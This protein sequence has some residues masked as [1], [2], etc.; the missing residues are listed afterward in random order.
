MPSAAV[1][2]SS[3]DVWFARA[4]MLVITPGTLVSRSIR[5]PISLAGLPKPGLS[6]KAAS[7]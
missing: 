6:W 2:V 3:K 1:V 4:N 7:V 5:K